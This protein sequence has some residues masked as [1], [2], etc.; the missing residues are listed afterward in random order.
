MISF[1]FG[2]AAYLLSL[3]CLDQY[4]KIQRRNLDNLHD[5][6]LKRQLQLDLDWRF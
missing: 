5:E 2:I 1:V 6:H 3:F 4:F